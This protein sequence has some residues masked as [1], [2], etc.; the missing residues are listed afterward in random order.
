MTHYLRIRVETGVPWPTAE[1]V[2]R[3]RDHDITLSPETETLA[4]TVLLAYDSDKMTQDQAM[5]LVR[6]FLS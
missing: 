1:T 4:P 6:R 2:V 5:L 3:F